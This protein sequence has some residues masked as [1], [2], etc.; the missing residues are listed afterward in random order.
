M[1]HAKDGTGIVAV[2]HDLNLA[3]QFA[4]RVVVMEKGRI[5]IDGP[6][7]GAITEDIMSRVF[8]L[9]RRREAGAE[10]P[11]VLPSLAS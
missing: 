8:R 5:V 1:T 10:R 11:Y 2:L 3:A 4:Q 7:H 6:A 9:E